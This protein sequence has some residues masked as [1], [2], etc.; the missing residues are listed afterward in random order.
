[1][2]ESDTENSQQASRECVLLLPLPLDE[3]QKFLNKEMS[4]LLRSARY[5][6]SKEFMI[7]ANNSKYLFSYHRLQEIHY[8]INK[9]TIIIIGSHLTPKQ[10]VNLENLF[11]C[12]VIDKFDLV[13]EIF[14]ARA[15]TEESKLQ[16]D[17]ARLKYEHPRERLR[18]MHRLGLDGAWHT[19]RSGFWGTGENPLNI[20]EARMTRTESRLKN[21]LAELS[22]QREKGRFSRKRHHHDSL[23]VSIVGYTSAGKSTLLNSLT[24]SQSSVSSR[25]FET[26][27]TR[28]RSFKLEDLKVFITDTVG[29]IE[30]LPTFLID[31]FKS[32]LEESLAADI[33]LIIVDG[34]EPAEYMLRKTRVSIQTINEINPQNY[35][36]IVINKIDLLAD[37]VLEKQL[38]CLKSHFPGLPIV[39]IAAINDIQPL[40]FEIDKF[41]P[42]QRFRCSYS[43]SYQF[44]SFCYDFTC[45]EHETF[46]NS[47]WE[48]IISLRKPKYGIEM[49][50]HRAQKLGIKIQMESI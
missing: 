15:M 46:E 36:I 33:L 12:K 41:R 40:I 1:M 49:L 38:K 31:S 35:R 16:I 44:R 14:A 5:F 2:Q 29:F 50:K 26:L 17:L 21:R 30:D 8:E 4:Q 19:E 47:D 18:L 42:K 34:S 37:R 48:M 13:L 11:E 6:I 9:P 20:F 45:V 28:I 22:K 39:P 10:G 7:N 43:P 3:R 23:Y 32:T 27:D 25:L 24:N